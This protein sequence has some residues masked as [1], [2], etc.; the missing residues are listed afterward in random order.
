MFMDLK[1]VVKYKYMDRKDDANFGLVVGSGEKRETGLKRGSR[2]S[3]S[4]V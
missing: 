3:R 2:Y 4:L 1:N